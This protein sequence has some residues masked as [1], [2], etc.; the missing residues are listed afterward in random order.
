M[1]EAAAGS[2]ADRSE[3]SLT[4]S[5]GFDETQQRH[6]KSRRK[7]EPGDSAAAEDDG[8]GVFEPAAG[9]ETR[10]LGDNFCLRDSDGFFPNARPQSWSHSFSSRENLQEV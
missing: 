9:P 6:H 5:F 1:L 3:K 4:L 8:G 2:A 7:Q 10:C